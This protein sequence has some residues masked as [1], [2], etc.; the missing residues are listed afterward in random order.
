[1]WV[2][3]SGSIATLATGFFIYLANF[4]PEL[5]R[6]LDGSAAAARRSRISRLKS[7]MANCSPWA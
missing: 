7:A 5:E 4:R 1:M 2:A 6:R 3:K